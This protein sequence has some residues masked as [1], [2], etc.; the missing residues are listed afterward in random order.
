LH[1]FVNCKM[2]Y[3]F[4]LTSPPPEKNPVCATTWQYIFSSLEHFVY[5]SNTRTFSKMSSEY[6]A[7]ISYGNTTDYQAITRSR[8]TIPVTISRPATLSL[9]S[10][11]TFRRNSI[12]IIKHE[13][14]G[15][16]LSRLVYF[17]EGIP[18]LP[19]PNWWFLFLFF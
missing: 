16:A 9:T 17:V 8:P 12:N 15:Q 5:A 18:L 6:T 2:C 11:R 14:Y 1:N 13:T 19:Q 10:G 4:T 3:I 7:C